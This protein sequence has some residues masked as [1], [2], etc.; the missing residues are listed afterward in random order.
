MFARLGRT[1]GAFSW[2]GP[3]MRSGL[4]TT[5]M[6]VRGLLG[7]KPTALQ[8]SDVCCLLLESL[9]PQHVMRSFSKV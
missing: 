6:P 4:P 8:H 1:S 2:P 7:A 5:E 3:Q 9:V